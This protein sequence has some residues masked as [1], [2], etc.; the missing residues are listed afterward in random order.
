V[1]DLREA[2]FSQVKKSNSVHTNTGEIISRL[3]G[4]TAR[5]K[6]GVKGFF[7]HVA[8]NILLLIGITGILFWIYPPMGIV[9]GGS[10]LLLLVVTG[11][12]SRLMYRKAVQY[13]DKEGRLAEHIH[14]ALSGDTGI[15]AFEDENHESSSA[16]ASLTHIQGRVTWAAHALFGVSIVAIILIGAQGISLGKLDASMFIAVMM[17]A[18]ILRAPMVQIARQGTRSGKILASL[19]RV[20]ALLDDDCNQGINKPLTLDHQISV[21]NLCLRRRKALGKTKAISISHLSIPAGSRVAVIG[22]AGAGKTCLLKLLSGDLTPSRGTISLDDRLITDN[23]HSSFSSTE[24]RWSH[25]RIGDVLGVSS[26]QK[27]EALEMLANIGASKLVRSLKAGLSTKVRSDELS[28][29]ERKAIGITRT[30]LSDAPL[31]LFDLPTSNISSAKGIARRIEIIIDACPN[32]TVL[33]SFR[34]PPP[35][36][37][38][39]RLLV[40][41]KGKVF[42]DSQAQSIM[43]NEEVVQVP[44]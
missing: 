28:F 23:G 40:L 26:A 42:E 44:E 12:G 7:V 6:A 33:M 22:K 10:C 21:T 4:D 3:I 20:V 29:S 43:T 34:H 35:T 8:A 24:P 36:D 38:F 27:S 2:A 39:D 41:R 18:M 1:R 9:L 19:E 11:I 14:D 32:Q 13:R 30:A 25:R 17:Y 31:L 15:E 16:E 5:I 37:A